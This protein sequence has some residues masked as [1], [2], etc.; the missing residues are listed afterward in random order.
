MKLYDEYGNELQLE[1]VLGIS[2]FSWARYDEG[3][4]ES[5]DRRVESLSAVVVNLLQLLQSKGIQLTCE[6]INFLSSGTSGYKTVERI[7]I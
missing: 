7:D 1:D 4:V 5:I 3:K 2:E 6:D